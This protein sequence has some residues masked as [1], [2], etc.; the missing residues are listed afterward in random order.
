[1][2]DCGNSAA[3]IIIDP[4][5]LAAVVILTTILVLGVKESFW[6]NAFTVLVS[7]IAIFLCIFLGKPAPPH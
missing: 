3:A 1:M 6:F 2:H 4:I 7:L 5:A